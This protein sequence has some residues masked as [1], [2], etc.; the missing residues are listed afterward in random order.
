MVFPAGM[1]PLPLATPVCIVAR[2]MRTR[3]AVLLCSVVI[4]LSGLATMT[5]CDE[6]GARRKVQAANEH[7]K[8]GRYTEARDLYEAALAKSPDLAI[9]HH[10]LGVTYY[11]LM[12]RG[13]DSPENQQVANRAGEHLTVYLKRSK[14]AK[15]QILLRKVLTELWV[16]SGQVDSALAFWESEHQARPKDTSVLEQLA[17]LNYKKGDWRK[18]IEWL[19]KAVAIAETDDAR[20]SAYGLIG[21]LCFLKLLNNKDSIQGAER[22]ELAD[23]GMGA[24]QKAHELQ[25]KN[26]G[27]VSVLANLNQQRAIA[28]SSR[29]GFHIDL[30]FHQNYMR[31]FGVLREEAKKAAASA[32]GGATGGTTAAAGGGS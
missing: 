2:L 3:F 20:A 6:I 21:N 29:L 10:N 12:K 28:S 26:M 32:E 23:I 30:A 31:V 16:E 9:A 13:D 22:I 7:Y 25:P 19:E 4:G 5:G 8:N 24:L 17:D 14:D 18:A 27:Y 1:P 15:E 11:R